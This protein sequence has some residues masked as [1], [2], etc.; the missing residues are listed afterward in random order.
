MDALHSLYDHVLL[1]FVPDIDCK[2]L[3]STARLNDHGLQLS[4]APD[5][6][7]KVINSTARRQSN[8]DFDYI[9]QKDFLHDKIT[10]IIEQL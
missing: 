5:I 10:S 3:N 6:D 2:A 8:M 7:Y 9:S 4:F 1:S